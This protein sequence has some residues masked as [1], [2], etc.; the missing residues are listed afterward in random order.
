MGKLKQNSNI[1]IFEILYK[2]NYKKL[3]FVS[4]TITR[5][6]EL[7]KD[8]VQQAFF[9]AYKKMNQLKDKEKFSAWIMKI[10]INEAKNLIKSISRLKVVPIVEIKETDSARDSFEYIY[11]IKDQVQRVLNALSPEDSE[12][13][14]LRYYSD[15]ALEDIAFI[16]NISSS[17]VKIRL[18]RAKINFRESMMWDAA[19]DLQQGG[20][21]S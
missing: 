5:D 6:R 4:Y 18:H 11:E 7:S 15:L 3:F 1:E 12:I 9:Q 16:L 2:Q 19:D 13:L 10:A 17:N 21:F 14:V 8:V 20:T